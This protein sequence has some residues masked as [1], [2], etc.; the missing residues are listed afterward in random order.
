VKEGGAGLNLD[1]TDVKGLV[2]VS[3]TVFC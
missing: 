1:R 2:M 3:H